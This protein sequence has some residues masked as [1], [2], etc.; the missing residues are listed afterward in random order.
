MPA[1]VKR[2]AKELL[3]VIKEAVKQGL[4]LAGS[5]QSVGGDEEAEVASTSGEPRNDVTR[6]MKSL[7]MVNEGGGT[8][9]WGSGIGFVV[10]HWTRADWMIGTSQVALSTSHSSLFGPSQSVWPSASGSPLFAASTSTLF[11]AVKVGSSGNQVSYC[12]G[13]EFELKNLTLVGVI[14]RFTFLG[15]FG[16]KSS[17]Q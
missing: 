16:G 2:R 14:C 8:D 11:G 15:F 4:S 10:L 7:E 17:P 13:L 12:N 3:D 9:L 6:E 5:V 1:V